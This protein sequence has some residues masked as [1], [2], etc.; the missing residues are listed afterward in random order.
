M[1]FFEKLDIYFFSLVFCS[2]VAELNAAQRLQLKNEIAVT[3]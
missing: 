2:D 3:D 1:Q